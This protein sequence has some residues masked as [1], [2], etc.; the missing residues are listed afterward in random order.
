MFWSSPGGAA[1]ISGA[2]N[3]IGGA[4][5]SNSSYKDRMH[6]WQMLNAGHILDA[7]KFKW[8]AHKDER[9]AREST[10]WQFDDLMQAADKSGIH[11]LAALG[12]ASS[13]QSTG[14][15]GTALPSGGVG[16]N[17][18]NF[19]GDA[20][21]EAIRVFQASERF[22][23][24]KAMDKADL[25]LRKRQ[26]DLL[27]SETI[28]NAATSRTRI[29][30]ARRTGTDSTEIVPVMV[31][32]NADNPGN[33]TER[34]VGVDLPVNMAEKNEAAGGDILGNLQTMGEWAGYWMDKIQANAYRALG[35]PVFKSGN[36]Y[37][38]GMKKKKAPKRASSKG[39]KD[40]R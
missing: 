14:A 17:D 24:Q 1:A 37:F 34:I 8:Q 39:R 9:F 28:L 29:A 30:E 31:Q 38:V 36:K 3:L 20:I 40:K 6:Q 32:A 2:A 11:R 22:Q 35:Y 13:Y 4:F 27:E 10:G 19:L 16:G 25:D 23:H 12:G 21:G 26:A 5:G 18:T 33:A 7:E 15:S